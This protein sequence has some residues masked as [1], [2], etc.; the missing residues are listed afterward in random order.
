[1]KKIYSLVTTEDTNKAELYLKGTARK[2]KDIFLFSQGEQ[3]DFFTYFNSFSLKKWRQYTTLQEI[4]L[5]LRLKGLF[6]IEFRIGSESGTKTILKNMNT[7]AL[8]RQ[9]FSLSD[10][11]GDILGFTITAQEEGAIYYGGTYYGKFAAWNEVRIGIGICTHKR[12][13]YVQRT[14]ET[15]REYQKENT[16]LQ[17]LVVDNG[18][19]LP[20]CEKNNFR[21]VHNPNYGGSGGFT[22]AMIEYVERNNVDYVLL[23]DDD[24]VLDMTAV[25]RTGS[26]LSGLKEAYKESFLSGAMLSLEKPVIQ[27]ENKACWKWIKNWGFGRNLNLSQM[28]NLIFNEKSY[29]SYNQYAAWWYC[30]I[31]VQRIKDIGYPLP[32]FVKCDDIE[33]GIR[34]R[35]EVISMNGIGVWHQ[36][37]AAKINQIIL[38]YNDRNNFIM[39]HYAS[40]GNRYNFMLA[41]I[42]RIFKRLLSGRMGDIKM[43]YLALRDYNK[44]FYGITKIGADERMAL[45]KEYAEKP[46]SLKVIPAI[47]GQILKAIGNYTEIRDANRKFRAEKMMDAAFW[48]TYLRLKK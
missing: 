15:L 23:M 46:F 14:I 3:L 7:D 37:F 10:V 19:T 31:P 48:R 47:L 40:G 22:R 6:A 43:M 45:V 35:K 32:F 18:N 12:E 24:I 9:T 13:N 8:Y 42:G 44:S 17:I 27:H 11:A 39:N 20:E 21:I 34:N 29:L 36:D 1:M 41:V 33:Y 16:W 38:Y 25:E 26:L 30:C 5:E 28:Q 2:E 4:T